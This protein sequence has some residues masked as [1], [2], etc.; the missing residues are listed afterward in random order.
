[1][2]PQNSFKMDD[3]VQR[4]GMRGVESRADCK[5]NDSGE[6]RMRMKITRRD[7]PVVAQVLVV[8]RKNMG[9]KRRVTEQAGF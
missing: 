2:S 4:Q 3:S 6:M 7:L 8:R 1:M 9:E 5:N